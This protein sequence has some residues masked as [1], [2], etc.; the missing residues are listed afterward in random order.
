M[1]IALFPSALNFRVSVLPLIHKVFEISN[2]QKT[3][4]ISKMVKLKFLCFLFLIFSHLV[5]G[6]DD[7]NFVKL[8]PNKY[9]GSDDIMS[10]LN[11]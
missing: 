5:C 6:V 8:Y 3:F 9:F 10:D 1:M 2:I 11:K 7:K 4:D